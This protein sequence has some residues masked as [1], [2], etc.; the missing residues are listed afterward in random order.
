MYA[1]TDASYNSRIGVVCMKFEGEAPRAEV[2]RNTRRTDFE[3]LAIERLLDYRDIVFPG[4]HVFIYTDYARA[5]DYAFPRATLFKVRGHTSPG[6]RSYEETV[7]AEVDE[8]ARNTLRRY[9][10]N[11]DVSRLRVIENLDEHHPDFYRSR[12]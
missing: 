4:V 3:L 7:F 11:T 12:R 9:P 10:R 5:F 2:Y 6:N 1:Y 8:F